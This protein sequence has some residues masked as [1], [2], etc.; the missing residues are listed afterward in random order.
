[1]ALNIFQKQDVA[2]SRSPSLA[3]PLGFVA[4]S[5]ENDELVR[6]SAILILTDGVSVA[7]PGGDIPAL[8]NFRTKYCP[9][10]KYPGMYRIILSC[11][12]WYQQ[13]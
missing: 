5:A 11:C 7:P 13:Q 12:S 6:N 10:G 3:P 2:S 9:S 4:E 1:M 8:R